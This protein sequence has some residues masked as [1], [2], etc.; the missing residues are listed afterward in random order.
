MGN[1]RPMTKAQRASFIDVLNDLPLLDSEF[2][3]EIDFQDMHTTN[4]T[5]TNQA[6][7]HFIN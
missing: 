5:L 3:E 4:L 2:D 7:T 6:S 1:Y